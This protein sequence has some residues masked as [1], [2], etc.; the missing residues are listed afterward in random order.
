MIIH[1]MHMMISIIDLSYSYDI[2][3]GVRT[4]LTGAS[5]Q[6]DCKILHLHQ[7][8]ATV[9]SLS[10]LLVVFRKLSLFLCIFPPYPNK[11]LS[12][13]Y[14]FQPCLPIWNNLLSKKVNLNLTVGC[15]GQAIIPNPSKSWPLGY[16]FQLTMAQIKAKNPMKK[17]GMVSTPQIP[18][19]YPDLSAQKR[20]SDPDEGDFYFS[21]FSLKECHFLIKLR[22]FLGHFQC[23]DHP[24]H[25]VPD[26]PRPLARLW[27]HPCLIS[28]E[29]QFQISG[30]IMAWFFFLHNFTER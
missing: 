29:K 18:P 10:F 8:T 19:N 24:G 14:E 25:A 23:E 5:Y 15:L 21:K 9:S 27:F 6:L 26:L 17:L 4:H 11:R 28:A 20:R 2:T 22:A 3:S 1:H 12:W 13:L 30:S 16:Q 7:R